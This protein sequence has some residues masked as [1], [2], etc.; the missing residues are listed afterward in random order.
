MQVWLDTYPEDFRDPP[1]FPA[2]HQL[3]EFARNNLPESDLCIKVN[4]KLEKMKR[5]E[6]AKGTY[7]LIYK[8]YNTVCNYITTVYILL[9]N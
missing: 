8:H 7:I 1:Q 9:K 3:L 6:D 4:Y 5:D 2:L